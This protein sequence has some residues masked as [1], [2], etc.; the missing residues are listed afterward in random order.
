MARGRMPPAAAVTGTKASATNK[1]EVNHVR[2]EKP[3]LIPSQVLAHQ[4]KLVRG[5]QPNKPESVETIRAI[6]KE[7][8]KATSDEKMKRANPFI[9]RYMEDEPSEVKPKSDVKPVVKVPDSV[10]TVEFGINKLVAA[11]SDE[12]QWSELTIGLQSVLER[13]HA[14][15]PLDFY[16][17]TTQG[18]NDAT[19]LAQAISDMLAKKENQVRLRNFKIGTLCLAPF[20][21]IYYRGEIVEVTGSPPLYTIHFSDYGNTAD[22][23]PDELIEMPDEFKKAPRYAINCQWDM[24]IAKELVKDQQDLIFEA[25]GTQITPKVKITDGQYL[26]SIGAYTPKKKL[27]RKSE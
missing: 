24:A 26:V 16:V 2:A 23:K 14:D 3:L 18:S 27:V 20:E 21:D 7:P 13:C 9:Q 12:L 19:M 17:Q 5:G 8:V 6:P 11:L 1:V 22:C 4:E 25:T 15:S 10:P